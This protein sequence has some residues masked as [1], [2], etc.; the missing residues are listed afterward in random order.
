[1]ICKF[2]RISIEGYRRLFSVNMEMRPLS[3]MIGANGMG[4]T[5]MLEV[6]SLL[7]ASAD[8]KLKETLSRSGGL[9]DVLT[10]GRTEHA[11]FHLTAEVSDNEQLEYV[12]T[13]K[14]RGISYEIASESLIQRNKDRPLLNISVPRGRISSSVTPNQ[15][16][17]NVSP[18]SIPPLKPHFPSH[19]KCTE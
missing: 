8:G 13:L 16:S 1:M 3:V 10:C 2:K 14:L 7:A 12:L 11:I 15:K 9:Q 17:R 19:P 18:G 6:F 5:S 4:K